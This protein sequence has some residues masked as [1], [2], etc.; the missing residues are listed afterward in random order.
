MQEC[1]S[2]LVVMVER[3]PAETVVRRQFVA[4]LV[5][6]GHSAVGTLSCREGHVKTIASAL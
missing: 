2:K 5:T 1:P 3:V 4:I 6:Q